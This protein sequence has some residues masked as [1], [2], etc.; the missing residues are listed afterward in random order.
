ML[1]RERYRFHIFYSVKIL[2][3][4]TWETF[5]LSFNSHSA[6]ADAILCLDGKR[7]SIGLTA[8]DYLGTGKLTRKTIGGDILNPNNPIRTNKVLE[9]L[10]RVED[11]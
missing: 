5:F 11:D 2:A 1:T 6:A 10:E 8:A 9:Y 3:P 4:A 7:H